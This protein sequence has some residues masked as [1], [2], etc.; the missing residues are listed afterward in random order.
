MLELKGCC[1][2]A[3][4]RA[5]GACLFKTG[6]TLPRGGVR[7]C[8][9]DEESELLHR[10][11]RDIVHALLGITSATFFSN[12]QMKRP[13]FALPLTDLPL[14]GFA[15]SLGHALSLHIKTNGENQVLA[16]LVRNAIAL[17]TRLFLVKEFREALGGVEPELF[18]SPFVGAIG[19]L[20]LDSGFGVEALSLLYMIV[21]SQLDEQLFSRH[22][23]ES[24][25]GKWTG[26]CSGC[27]GYTCGR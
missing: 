22:R 18:L 17:A 20:S 3:L 10:T 6:L 26:L 5:L 24:G 2:P 25:S 23:S 4:L 9:F 11:R 7:W 8:E 14:S 1:L 21:I 15:E 19:F 12:D 13:D 16:D 27:E